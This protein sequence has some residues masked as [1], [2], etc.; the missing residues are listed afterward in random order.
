[1][2]RGINVEGQKW[3]CN[4]LILRIK[5]IIHK[6]RY[7]K[8]RGCWLVSARILR[9]RENKIGLIEWEHMYLSLPLK[10]YPHS[11]TLTNGYV[12]RVLDLL[13]DEGMGMAVLL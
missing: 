12:S 5:C 11:E 9:I 3:S 8:G 2:E 10:I 6:R 4:L 13:W 1:M 7:N